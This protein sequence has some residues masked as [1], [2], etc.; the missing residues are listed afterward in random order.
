M[1]FGVGI[2]LVNIERFAK[3]AEK[4]TFVNKVFTE[5][6][7]KYA[8]S[9]KTPKR[10]SEI[11]AGNFAVKEAF[12][13]A[14]GTGIR[15][16]KLVEIEVDRDELGKPVVNTSGSLSEIICKKNIKNIHVSISHDANFATAICVLEGGLDL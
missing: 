1:I 3:S 4:D 7:I 5:K 11:L 6:E 13:K 16:F 9:G 14:L 12:S 8:F 10:K 15:D 2:D